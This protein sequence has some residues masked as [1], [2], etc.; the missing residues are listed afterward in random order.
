MKKASLIVISL[1][2]FYCSA[3]TRFVD[4]LKNVLGKEQNQVVKFD[5]I[6]QIL[7]NEVNT[8]ANI[9]TSLCIRMVQLA[10]N[11]NSDSLLAIGYNMVGS[12][13][14]RKGDYST[15]LEYLFKALP[16]AERSKDKRRISSIYFDISLTYIIIGKPK[17]A[18]YY[19][20]KGKDNLP[21]SSNKLYDFMAS[22]F[23]RNMVRY[24]LLMNHLDS[25]LPYLQHLEL[26]AQLLK[27]PVVVLP[28]LFLSGAAYARLN[29]KDSAEFYF[30]KAAAFSDSIKSVGLKWTNDRYYIPYLLQN[31]RLKEAKKRAID[32]LQLG[33]ENSN[34][35]VRL[36]AASFLRAV[37]ERLNQPDSAYHFSKLELLMKDS[38][39]SQNNIN[40]EETLAFNEKLKTMEDQ[41]LAEMRKRQNEENLS[42]S[43]IGAAAVILAITFL[44]YLRARRKDTEN[45]LAKQRERISRELHDNIGSQLTYISGNIDWLIDS[46]GSLSD[47][48]E[49]K[50]LNVVSETSKNIVGDLREA[51][52]TI[53]KESIKLEELSDRIKYFLREQL[54]LYPEIGMEITEEIKKDYHLDPDES[55]NA[56]RICQEAISNCAKHAQCSG[57]VLKIYSDARIKYHFS[58]S[59]NGNGFNQ[60]VQRE[61]HYGLA[62]MSARAKEIGAKL[63]IES[64]PGRGTVITILKKTKL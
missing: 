10:Q 52:W 46:R 1:I 15:A 55:L 39:F 2:S 43:I 42:F 61:G 19:N 35:D 23:D 32:L 13:N 27:T 64:K 9:D 34:W 33:E 56:Y 16:L 14:G 26:E 51:I 5:L 30:N 49:I 11:L 60:Q 24:Y 25:T 8:G 63:T 59:D 41:H 7:E 40:K 18:R 3:Q 20:L 54:A 22:Q 4:S 47:E 48:E 28:S 31:G 53:K 37:Y 17:E 44:Y 62:N 29:N 58:I 21:D 38:V 50:K 36:T 45:K 6:N 57:I 12:F